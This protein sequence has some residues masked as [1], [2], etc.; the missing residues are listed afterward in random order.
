[1]SLRNIGLL[2]ATSLFAMLVGTP[3]HSATSE[4]MPG[5]KDFCIWLAQDRSANWSD[6]LAELTGFWRDPLSSRSIIYFSRERKV[7][8]TTPPSVPSLSFVEI[9]DN[10]VERDRVHLKVWTHHYLGGR[11]FEQTEWIMRRNLSGQKPATAVAIVDAAGA[12]HPLILDRRFTG[13]EAA[14]F[15]K[16]LVGLEEECLNTK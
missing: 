12:T 8:T 14:D 13:R 15:M 16:I 2:L 11:R 10:D 7:I 5:Q 3:T 9:L 6:D 1:M 4:L